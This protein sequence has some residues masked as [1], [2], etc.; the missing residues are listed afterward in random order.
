MVTIMMVRTTHSRWQGW[1]R[2]ITETNH[3][4]LMMTTT[5]QW[6]WW[7]WWRTTMVLFWLFCEFSCSLHSKPFSFGFLVD[8]WLQN[9]KTWYPHTLACIWI[10]IYI[11]SVR[12][13]ILMERLEG[14]MAGRRALSS[15]KPDYSRQLWINCQTQK[16]S[17]FEWIF[18]VADYLSFVTNILFLTACSRSDWSYS[19]LT[20]AACRVKA[21]GHE[22]AI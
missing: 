17:N 2:H 13:S 5:V 8:L 21:S 7:K 3:D 10:C 1:C 12:W 18:V 22:S 16:H 9:D 11:W 19:F 4:N 20:F 14:R 15:G 6:W